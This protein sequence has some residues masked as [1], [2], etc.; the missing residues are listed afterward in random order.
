[1]RETLVSEAEALGFEKGMNKK[2]RLGKLNMSE[3]PAGQTW[4]SIFQGEK[5]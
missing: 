5:G 1:M 4:I 3:L 2:E